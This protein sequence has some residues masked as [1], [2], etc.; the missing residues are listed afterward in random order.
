M[1]LHVSSEKHLAPLLITV[2]SSMTR[3]YGVEGEK[4]GMFVGLLI[5]CGD[6]FMLMYLG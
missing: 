5:A 6:T 4:E 3:R 2:G 1:G